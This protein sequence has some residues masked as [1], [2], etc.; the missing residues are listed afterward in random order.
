[1]IGRRTFSAAVLAE[2]IALAP[3]AAARAQPAKA[4]LIGV[5]VLG[6][7]PP[8]LLLRVF[9]EG[10][11]KR[12]YVEGKN[13]ALAVR[14]ADG[15]AERL[16][17][18]A[19][20]LVRLRVNII[21][22]WQTPAVAAARRATG[23]IPIVM[24]GAADPVGNGFI[25]SLARPG[26]NV[27]GMTGSGTEIYRKGLELLRETVPTARSF[28]VL[29]NATDPFTPVYLRQL[30]EHARTAALELHV[31][32]VRP[33]DDL[34]EAFARFAKARL[35]GLIVQPSLLSP[36]IAVLALQHRLP[37]ISG[38]REF[39]EG[40]GLMSY[41]SNQAEMFDQAARYVDLILK[42]RVPAELPVAQASRFELVINLKTAKALR[43]E[44]PSLLLVRADELI[45]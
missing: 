18:A 2:L 24:A 42:G 27:T 33:S 32:K 35:Q 29:A 26:G 1:M 12:G 10:L 5:L 20:E 37:S 17:D 14:S 15:R 28:G 6:S 41:A 44:V 21:V 3:N 11:R 36:A 43:L 40:G 38:F 13:I 7:P 8:D 16:P 30:E 31:A 4:P 23:D 19:A 22:A 45:E 34:R 39:A 25:A 9:R